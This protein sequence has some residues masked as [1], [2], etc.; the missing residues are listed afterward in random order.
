MSDRETGNGRAIAFSRG[1]P[2]I[3]VMQADKIQ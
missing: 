1:R 2:A 3:A